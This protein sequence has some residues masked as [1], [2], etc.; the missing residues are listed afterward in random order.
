MALEHFIASA[1]LGHPSCMLMVGNP[2][3]LLPTEASFS[4]AVES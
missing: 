1:E 3:R 2:Q 4:P